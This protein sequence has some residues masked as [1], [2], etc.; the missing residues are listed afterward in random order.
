[1]SI[2]DARQA[3]L[4]FVQYNQ[5]IFLRNHVVV[6]EDTWGAAALSRSRQLM[7]GNV[8]TLVVLGLL[9]FVIQGSLSF[10]M[11]FV[12]PLILRS[13]LLNI[14]MSI[15]LVFSTAVYVVF[16]FSCRCSVENFDLQMLA[17]AVATDDASDQYFAER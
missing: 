4:Y 14:I 8:G 11:N 13:I 7:K 1:M 16:Y 9:L 3:L 12:N 2:V 17:D 15:V 6:I 5:I 10:G